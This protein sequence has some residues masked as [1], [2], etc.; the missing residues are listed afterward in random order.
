MHK[1]RN[2]NFRIVLY[3]LLTMTILLIFVVF[4]YV[5]MRKTL[6]AELSQSLRRDV[7][8]V[9]NKYNEKLEQIVKVTKSLGYTSAIQKSIFSEDGA[10]KIA[11]LS[12]SRELI[13]TE[14]DTNKYITDFF[15]YSDAGHLYTTSEYLNR[16]R[17]NMRMYNFDKK[18]TLDQGF[19]SEEVLVDREA[20][21]LFYYVPIY[22]TAQGIAHKTKENGICAVLCDFSPLL[23]DC[24]EILTEDASCYLLYEGRVISSLRPFEGINALSL[25]RLNEGMD[26]YE[27][28]TEKYNY[29]S[30]FFGR[31]QVVCFV[32]AEKAGF[33]NIGLN[34]TFYLMIA[35][36]FIIFSA[37]LISLNREYTKK[38]KR[39]LD[40]LK[41]LE[42]NE[43]IM[44]VTVP[45][46]P[47][48]QEIAEEINGMLERLE[49]SAK[50]ERETRDKLL[51]ATVA[52]QDAEMTAY[53]SQINPHF[54]FNTLECVRS[55][56]QYY[57][58]SMIEDI[59]TAMSK[60]FRYSLYSDLTV[61]LSS[62]IDMLDQYFLITCYRFPDRYVM[63]K[64]IDD[65]VLN[66]IVPSMIMQPLVEN[67]IKHAFVSDKKGKENI[68]T[69]RA[70][71]TDEGLLKV[72]VKDNGRGMSEDKLEELRKKMLQTTGYQESGRDSIGIHNIYERLKLFDKRNEME[73]YSEEG[74]YTKVELTLYA[75]AIQ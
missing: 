18:I 33:K 51:S 48:L 41:S 23:S 72:V 22:R 70:H 20:T 53:R 42:L 59:I 21:F 54:F 9:E 27:A 6:S 30:H 47:E 64:E 62:E 66:Y 15:Y 39:M 58:A 43:E 35:A 28:P 14:R 50:R 8:Y 13:A 2:T 40:E 11:N 74:Q 49:E 46:T 10:E 60:I 29:Y 26:V 7:N 25:M 31:F 57:N 61:P 67:C 32:P 17:S 63:K 38:T 44:R 75:A 16:F 1:K 65:N 45:K 69:V 19:M 56:A 5:S 34:R 36:S 52:Q 68:I 55:M 3:F 37:L 4:Y 73:F 24:S 71:Y 12:T